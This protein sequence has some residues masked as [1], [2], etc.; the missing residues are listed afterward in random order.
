MSSKYI[1]PDFEVIMIHI[2]NTWVKAQ[3]TSTGN[4]TY[5][6]KRNQSTLNV[7]W[8]SHVLVVYSAFG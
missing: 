1:I 4:T 6:R 8:W 3:Q 7:L 5:R 2:Y